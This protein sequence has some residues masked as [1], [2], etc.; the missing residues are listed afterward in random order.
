M[1]AEPTPAGWLPDPTGRHQ[2]RYWD[3][4]QWT[5]HVADQGQPGADPY[6]ALVGPPPLPSLPVPESDP[7]LAQQTLWE[8]ETKNLTS[9]AT[10]G[11]VVSKRYRITNEAIYFEQGVLSSTAE[12]VPLWAVRDIDVRQSIFQKQRGVGNVA[13]RV[14]HSDYT[15]RDSVLL[16]SVE[17]PIGLRDLLNAHV[18]RARLDHDRRQRTHY[19]GQPA[20]AAQTG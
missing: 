6:D 1:M 8:G 5:E 12:Q 17:N 3:G 14:Q 15:G 13:V 16:E 19:Y 4:A 20:P 7:V 2:L 18:Q 11:R 9:M 10:S